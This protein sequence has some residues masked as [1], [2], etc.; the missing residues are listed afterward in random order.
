MYSEYFIN[1]ESGYAVGTEGMIIKTTNGG[2][3][4]ALQSSG[5]PHLLSGVYFIDAITGYVVGEL[6]TILKTTNGGI[7]WFAQNSGINTFIRSVYF[8]DSNI[9][10]AYGFDGKLLKTTNGGSWI[11]EKTDKIEN[12]YIYPNPSSK[13]INITIYGALLKETIVNI[14][15]I[16]GDNVFSNTIYNQ[17]SMGIDINSLVNGIYMIKIQNENGFAVKKLV[18]QK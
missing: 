6:G 13:K 8:I 16:Q 14:F 1:S 11:E 12:I 3:N 17:N 10:Y 4:W 5:T 9:G 15:N 18:I 2:A 7:N